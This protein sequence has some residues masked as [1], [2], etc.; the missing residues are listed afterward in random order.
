MAAQKFLTNAA[1]VIT[2]I[3]A[4][5]SSAGAGDSGKI[6]SLDSTGKL[7]T[8]FMPAGIAADT[9]VVVASEALSAGAWVN[10]WS[11]SGTFKARN[12]DATVAGKEAHGFVIA[13]VAS[14]GNA[15]VYFPGSANSGLSGMTPGVV[16]LTTTPG[17]GGGT[18][19]S[20]SGNVVQRLGIATS[21]SVVIFEPAVPIV[22]A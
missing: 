13:S 12:A 3:A 6:P 10:I 17:V 5:A 9:Q 11:S 19:P 4:N 18:A 14:A 22:L 7:D 21:A 8:S 2:E 15:T 20:S 16:Y 1:G